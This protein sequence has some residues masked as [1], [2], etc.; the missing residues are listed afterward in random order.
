MCS[1][2]VLLAGIRLAR[3]ALTCLYELK[4]VSYVYSDVIVTLDDLKRRRTYQY[5]IHMALFQNT[6]KPS[7]LRLRQHVES[8][9]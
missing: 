2:Y 4:I 3:V 1:C 5:V 6:G 8:S 9:G 7:R